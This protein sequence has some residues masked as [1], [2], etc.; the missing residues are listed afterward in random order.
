M[1]VDNREQ[2]KEIVRKSMDDWLAR[3]SVVVMGK[4][5]N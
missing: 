3:A 4:A 1:F 5:N 2:D